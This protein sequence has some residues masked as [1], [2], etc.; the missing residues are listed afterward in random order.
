MKKLSTGQ[1]ST[2]GNWRALAAVT[3]GEDSAATKFLDEKIS[4]EGANAE[5]VADEGQ[6]IQMLWEMSKD[7][8]SEQ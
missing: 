1:D 6:T 7:R 3:F 5:V 8:M 2:L 4:N